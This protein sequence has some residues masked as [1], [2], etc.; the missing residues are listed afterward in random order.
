MAKNMNYW[1]FA[2]FPIRVI[3][4]LVLVGFILSLWVLS[5]NSRQG[6]TDLIHKKPKNQLVAEIP[7][8]V[9]ETNKSKTGSR[10]NPSQNEKVSAI[11]LKAQI[12]NKL[13]QNEALRYQLLHYKEQESHIT[14][15]IQ[16][17][18]PSSEEIKDIRATIGA[19]QRSLDGNLAEKEEFDKWIDDVIADYDC[20][21]FSGHKI[22]M[23]SIPENPDEKISAYS[24]H[25]NDPNSELQMF[26]NYN[27]RKFK[28]DKVRF[29]IGY[30]G[31]DNIKR[32][33]NL[34]K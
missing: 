13:Q 23:I 10:T 8:N 20:L 21:G 32:F 1:R 17:A 3:W 31:E 24:Y 9:W 14:Y 25:S 19:A 2:I 33:K 30:A 7:P 34:I 11:D 27:N 4:V 26:K 5:D 18:P 29:Y 28:G 16:I 6:A 12:T 15:M 22:V